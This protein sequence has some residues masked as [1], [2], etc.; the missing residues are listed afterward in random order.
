[1]FFDCSFLV[2][3]VDGGSGSLIFQAALAGIFAAAFSFKSVLL[4][5]RTAVKRK[6]ADIG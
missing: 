2:G 4:K 1:M 3:Y 6:D 5:I